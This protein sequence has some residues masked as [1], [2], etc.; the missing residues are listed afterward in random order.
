MTSEPAP[1]TPQDP[2]LSVFDAPPAWPKVIGWISVAWGSVW[3]ACS[4]CGMVVA[5]LFGGGDSPFIKQAEEKMG[6]MPE[7]MK[8]HFDVLQIAMMAVGI[9]GLIVLICA[10]VA[11]IRRSY[12]GRT[13]HLVYAGVSIVSSIVGAIIGFQQQLRIK[14][15]VEANSANPWAQQ[16]SSAYGMIGLVVG[17]TIGLCWPLFCILWFGL[18]KRTAESFGKVHDDVVI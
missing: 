14:T 15:W 16:G 7:V 6:P 2:D 10:G 13:L 11:T 18:I 17:V 1:V 8:P 3:L 5:L 9:V 12:A 4:A